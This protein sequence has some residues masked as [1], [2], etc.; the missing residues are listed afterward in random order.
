M[1]DELWVLRMVYKRY[2][3]EAYKIIHR[4]AKVNQEWLFTK[5][6]NAA[7]RDNPMKLSNS[8][9]KAKKRKTLFS[10]QNIVMLHYFLLYTVVEL[11]CGVGQSE[12]VK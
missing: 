7:V 2:V 3:K 12:E 6:H 8:K 5:S 9:F 1:E 11:K 10:T 4:I